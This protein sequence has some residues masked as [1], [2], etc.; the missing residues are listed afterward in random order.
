MSLLFRERFGGGGQV[1]QSDW[2]EPIYV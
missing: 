2:P 1:S